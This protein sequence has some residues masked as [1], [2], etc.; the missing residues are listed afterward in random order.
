MSGKSLPQLPVDP[1]SLRTGAMPVAMGATPALPKLPARPA[2]LGLPGKALDLFG[3]PMTPQ[4]SSPVQ[5]LTGGLHVPSVGGPAKQLPP[6]KIAAAESST[7]SPSGALLA[8]AL[9]GMFAAS[10]GTI[11]LAR[12]ITGRR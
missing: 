6:L 3:R 8:L 2:D 10:A 4:S 1:E 9:G 5:N 11:S 7:G 12:R